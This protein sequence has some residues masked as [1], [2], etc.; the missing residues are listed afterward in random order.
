MVGD[1]AVGKTQLCGRLVA[2]SSFLSPVLVCQIII[3]KQYFPVIRFCSN[4][5]NPDAVSTDQ[6]QFSTKE[7][8]FADF[9][10]KAQIWDT[11]GKVD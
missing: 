4:K 3:L 7:F 5:Y 9:D 6:L 11:S 1:C 10:I 2:S 8:L